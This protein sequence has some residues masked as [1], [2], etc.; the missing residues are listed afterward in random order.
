MSFLT[1]LRKIGRIGEVVAPFA[2]TTI[3]PAAGAITG[4]VVNTVVNAEAA[5]GS[6]PDNKEQVMRHV[7]PVAGPLVSTILAGCG[8]T[9][10][11]SGNAANTTGR[12]SF[13]EIRNPHHAE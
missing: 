9:S 10:E 7:L 12:L 11:A 2:I 5:G 3:N 6:G 4:M 13:G 8:K 1:T